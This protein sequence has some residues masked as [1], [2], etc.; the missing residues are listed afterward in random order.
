MHYDYSFIANSLLN[1]RL[2]LPIRYISK[3]KK[4]YSSL[5]QIL[6]PNKPTKQKNQPTNQPTNQPK[7]YHTFAT[8]GYL[9]LI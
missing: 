1:A 2:S 7:T 5:L 8:P 9:I 4:R 3:K 6:A